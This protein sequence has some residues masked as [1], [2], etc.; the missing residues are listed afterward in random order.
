M[1]LT[2]SSGMK[3]IGIVGHEGAKFTKAGEQEARRIIREIL[4]PKSVVLVSGHCHLGGIDMWAE[5]EAKKLG[6]FD[7]HY[8]F[9][10]ATKSWESGYKPRNIRIAKV[11]DEVHVIVANEFPPTYTGKRFPFCYHCLT[12]EHIKSGGCWTAK[13]AEKT[14]GTSGIW[15]VV[16]QRKELA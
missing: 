7:A 13:Y 1:A 5:E 12:E 11:S 15:H 10:P 3:R 6:R 9:P 2:E 16:D 4:A 8:I 14:Y